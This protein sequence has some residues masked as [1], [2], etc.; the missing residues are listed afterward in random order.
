MKEKVNNFLIEAGVLP[1]RAS[2]KDENAETSTSEHGK[3]SKLQPL[4]DF[5]SNS[6][7]EGNLSLAHLERDPNTMMTLDGNIVK[8]AL[9]DVNQLH[10]SHVEISC[11]T[12]CRRNAASR[13]PRRTCSE[14]N[15][16]RA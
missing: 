9:D 10:E 2:V 16:R 4:M 14:V 15:H 6:G 11:S 12:R 1:R 8:K 5:L 3:R 7:P 13:I